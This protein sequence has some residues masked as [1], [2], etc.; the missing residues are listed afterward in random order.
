MLL[1][2]LQIPPSVPQTS[3][4]LLLNRQNLQLHSK[5]P[6]ILIKCFGTMHFS[7]TSKQRAFLWVE[8][9]DILLWMLLVAILTSR[10]ALAIILYCFQKKSSFHKDSRSISGTPASAF[11]HSYVRAEAAAQAGYVPFDRF[12]HLSRQ[13]N[14][15][16]LDT[17]VFSRVMLPSWTAWW[18]RAE[19]RLT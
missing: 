15:R 13:H 6:T 2:L 19:G 17:C 16:N 7:R 12:Y 5:F 4:H 14:I 3:S 10:E 11:L 8:W 9:L 18:K 1:W